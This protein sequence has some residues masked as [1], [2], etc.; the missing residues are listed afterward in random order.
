MIVLN[1]S[2]NIKK[3]ENNAADMKENESERKKDDWKRMITEWEKQSEKNEE[4]CQ[5]R[6]DYVDDKRSK[7]KI[8]LN[9]SEE[10][11]EQRKR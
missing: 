2:E 1:E 4:N 8:G 7:I 3:L 9:S 6:W 11:K 5:R 10:E